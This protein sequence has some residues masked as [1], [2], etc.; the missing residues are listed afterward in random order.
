MLADSS[1]PALDGADQ[2]F[3]EVYGKA[4][5]DSATD[6]PLLVALAGE[7]ALHVRRERR[8]FLYSHPPF[9]TAK[10]AAHVAVALYALTGESG[11][12]RMPRETARRLE[13]IHAHLKGALDRLDDAGAETA[14]ELEH[15]L[16][17]LL[18]SSLE[19][20]QRALEGHPD[21]AADRENFARSNGPIILRV[22]EIATRG[23][24]GA[25]HDAFERSLRE[26]SEAERAAMQVVVVGDHQARSRSLGMQY[27]RR[28]F[29]ESEGADDRVTY[30]ENVADEAEAIALVGTRRLDCAIAR[31]FFADEKRL[32]RDVLGDAAKRCL[33]RMQLTP[34]AGPSSIEA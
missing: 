33:E 32:Q 10:V 18:R 16:Q 25:L 15:E 5:S 23:Q 14:A 12:D 2:T 27:F 6:A 31:A 21:R 13:S 7:L 22:T 34:I 11:A 24:I 29:A 4:R 28:R 8:S 1:I 26:L 9:H 30:G 20:A 3:R 19:Y 17:P